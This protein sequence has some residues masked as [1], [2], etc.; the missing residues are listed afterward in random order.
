MKLVPRRGALKSLLSLGG[1]ALAAGLFTRSAVAQEPRVIEIVAK[2][3]KFTPEEIPL[4]LGERVILALTSL[5]YE[6]GFS[7]PDLKLRADFV[8]GQVIRVELQP[9]VA[10]NLDF[11]CDNFCGDDHEDMHG[12]FIVS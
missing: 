5:D 11:V 10:G 9:K 4:K 8:P 6:H 2:R 1:S 7:V 12:R 3:F